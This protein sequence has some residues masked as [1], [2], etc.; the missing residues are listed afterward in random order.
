MRASRESA[1]LS[2]SGVT[3]GAPGIEFPRPP[4]LIERS[5]GVAAR[6]TDP[7]TA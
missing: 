4:A 6:S 7:R 3:L 1:V 5:G 2:E